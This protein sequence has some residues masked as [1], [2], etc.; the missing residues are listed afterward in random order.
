VLIKPDVNLSSCSESSDLPVLLY[1][2][3]LYEVLK[4]PKYLLEFL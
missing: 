4:E 3:E 1:W 2:V